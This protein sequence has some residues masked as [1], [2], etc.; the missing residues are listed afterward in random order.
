M[1]TDEL[2][3]RVLNRLDQDGQAPYA[4][5]DVL[6]VLNF[7]QR[8]FAFLTLCLESSQQLILTPGVQFY[9]LLQQPGFERFIVP[10]RVKLLVSEAGISSEFGAPLADAV[11][12]AEEDLAALASTAPRLRPSTVSDLVALD[13]TWQ[14]ATGTPSRYGCLGLD[15]F[16]VY[17]T[18]AA[19]MKLLV[20]HARGPVDLVADDD[21]PEIPEADHPALVEFAVCWLPVAEGGSQLAKHIDHM[22]RFLE[23]ANARAKV[24]RARSQ[25]QRYDKLPFEMENWDASRLLGIFSGKLPARKGGQWPLGA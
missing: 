6:R 11:E 20:T 14:S 17:K 1:N 12:F 10:L 13:E 8:L 16:F 22:Q 7:G 9:H 15:L 19:G 4:D 24:V 2:Q 5:A 18:P 23:A 3:S 21:V 25:A